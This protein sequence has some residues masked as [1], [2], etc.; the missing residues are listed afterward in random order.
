MSRDILLARFLNNGAIDNTFG[1]NGR[2]LLD[3]N[4]GGSDNVSDMKL[5]ANN[6]IVIVGRSFTL[7]GQYLIA[8]LLTNGDLDTSFNHT[9]M[10]SGGGNFDDSWHGC[11]LEPNGDITVVGALSDAGGSDKVIARYT[12]KGTLDSSF[13]F[14]GMNVLDEAANEVFTSIFR[15]S[16]N[17]YYM[18]GNTTGVDKLY[19]YDSTGNPVGSFG[20]SGKFSFN[21]PNGLRAYVLDVALEGNDLFIA[22]YAR[23]MQTN[24]VDILVG[25]MNDNGVLN[26]AFGF[27]G[28][29]R[30][31]LAS[32]E[33]DLAS[34][35]RI[36]GDGSIFLAGDVDDANGIS[37]PSSFLLASDGS[38][39]SSYGTNGVMQYPV[40][41]SN[42]AYTTHMTQNAQGQFTLMLWR[43]GQG[44]KLDAALLRLKTNT[45]GIGLDEPTRLTQLLTY[46]NPAIHHVYVQLV[47]PSDDNLI[48]SLVDVSGRM[49]AHTTTHVQK[50]PNTIDLS[51]L[52]HQTAPGL[53]LLQ[54]HNGEQWIAQSKLMLE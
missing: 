25:K 39:Y 31:D 50:G 34:V 47:G 35:I 36:L 30:A 23:N 4:L 54:V 33:N 7:N 17:R 51:H 10:V 12:S 13:G 8:R 38:L 43:V 1:N 2:V 21:L 53:Y 15:Q 41:G 11:T 18:V 14:N 27:N 3:P 19:A 32:G 37:I 5:D 40:N 24:K 52:I 20:T 26:T 6:N 49:V 44:G 9:G 46:P 29:Y 42:I 45:S 16:N 48:F 28:Y 22:G